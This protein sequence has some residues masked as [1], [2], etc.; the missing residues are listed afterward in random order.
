[1]QKGVRANTA[2]KSLLTGAAVATTA[3]SGL[4]GARVLRAG[5]V[6]AEGATVPAPGTPDD[7]SRDQQR[8]RIL[9]WVTPAL[10]GLIVVLG[11]QQGEQQRPTEVARDLA[12]RVADR[13][14]GA[15]QA[16]MR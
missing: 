3:Y 5:P 15:A 10:T 1:V 6:P 16:V 8:L 12:Q 4:M 9:Q 14:A 2:V 11:A 7:T 13:A